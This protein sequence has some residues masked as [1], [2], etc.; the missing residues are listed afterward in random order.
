MK[1]I[2]RISLV[3]L[4]CVVSGMV[5]RAETAQDRGKHI[6]DDCV[7]ALGGSGFLSLD[8]VVETGRASSFYRE[9]LNGLTIARIARHFLNKVEDPSKTLAVLERDDFGKKLDYGV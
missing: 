2:G 5:A 7:E 3:V 9:R 4:A 1:V 6:V 8:N